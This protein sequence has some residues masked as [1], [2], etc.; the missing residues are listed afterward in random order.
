MAKVKCESPICMNQC[1]LDFMSTFDDGEKVWLFCS[2]ICRNQHLVKTLDQFPQI[3]GRAQESIGQRY[4]LIP[5][6]P[7]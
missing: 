3:L 7:C 4:Q 6:A 5:A 1:E 2:K